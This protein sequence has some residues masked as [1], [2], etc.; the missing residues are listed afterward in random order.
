MVAILI[1][2]IDFNCRFFFSSKILFKDFQLKFFVSLVFISSVSTMIDYEE[3][4]N[5]CYLFYGYGQ[6]FIDGE[7]R[8]W[9]D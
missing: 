9:R 3:D 4:L 1:K 8:E 6:H 5:P 2:E 7:Y